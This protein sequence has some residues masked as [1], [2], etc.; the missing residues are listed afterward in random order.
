MMKITS[1]FAPVVDW[2]KPK[3]TELKEAPRFEEW[4]NEMNPRTPLVNVDEIVPVVR[5]TNLKQADSNEAPRFEEWFN[6]MNPRTP[7]PNVD[8]FAEALYNF[9]FNTDKSNQS[10]KAN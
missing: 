5:W 7:V 2:L 9:K 6:E 4:F 1:L 10:L 3:Q 8:E